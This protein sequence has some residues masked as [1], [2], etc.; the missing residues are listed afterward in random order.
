MP[1][2]LTRPLIQ[3]MNTTSNQ[4]KVPIIVRY[5]EGVVTAQGFVAGARPKYHYGFFR[6]AA[7]DARPE[8]VAALAQAP[9]V[10]KIWLD[11]PVHTCLDEAVR[12]I[13]VP[14]VWSMGLTGQGIRIAIVD[15]GIDPNHP[16]FA[17]RIAAAVSLRGGSHRDD[18]GHGTH[19]AGIAAGSGAASGG[20]YRGIAPGATLYVAK[21]LD[22]KGS[23]MMSD[24]MAG[25]E[26]A[27]AQRVH[28]ICLSLGSEGAGDGTDALSETCD[29]A[30][31]LGIVVC[32]AAGNAG[33]RSGSIGAPGCA[34]RVITVGA[35]S[36]TRDT[37]M[38][39]SGRGPTK[40]RRVKPDIC[41]PG[42]N[43]IS[44]R[45]QGTAI[46]R[47]I[48][49]NYVE[50]SGTSMAVPQ[51]V[52]AVALILQRMPGLSPDQVKDLL[53]RTAVDMGLDQNVQ[54]GGRADI[55]RAVNESNLPRPYPTD[56]T[57]PAPVTPEPP[58]LSTPT[59]PLRPGPGAAGCSRVVVNIL[60][61]GRNPE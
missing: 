24:V 18:N 40:D 27:V 1:G 34:R 53:K 17:G 28:V 55:Y 45:A 23:G 49:N 15:T 7:W 35:T 44:C 25:V 22:S 37:V 3:A 32:T 48:D 56:P 39:F 12:R 2:K 4:A 20:R 8:D 47:T 31:G 38:D 50:T 41:F 13:Q 5:R 33:P 52:G 30:V 46:G 21:S 51:A 14:Q 54:G 29:M 36:S 6:G 60:K 9:E 10:E 11:L 19:V 61:R 26:W 58:S 43:I 57:T 59:V 16:D 42:E